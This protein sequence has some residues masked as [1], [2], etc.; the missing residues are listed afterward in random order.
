[1]KSQRE[2]KVHE[3]Y[4][5]HSKKFPN[6][7]CAGCGIGIVLGAI[8][9]AVDGPLVSVYGVR[10]E[11]VDYGVE[12]AYREVL[13]RLTGNVLRNAEDDAGEV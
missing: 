11:A 9:R 2:S 6:V 7:W 4:L 13:H 3:R 1:M 5:R 12:E 8:I 10:P